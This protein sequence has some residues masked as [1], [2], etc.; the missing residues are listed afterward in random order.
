M[1]LFRI[2]SRT[3]GSLEVDAENW[4]TA[5][6]E[7]LGTFGV[8][9]S[10]DRIACEALPNGQI[11]VRDVRTGSGWVVAPLEG[12]T[13][14]DEALVDDASFPQDPDEPQ[15]GGVSDALRE[16]QGALTVEEAARRAVEAALQLVPAE[17]GAVLVRQADDA[18]K[19][20]F[21]SGPGS[22]HLLGMRVPAGAGVAGFCVRRGTALAL[23]DAYADPRFLKQM[24]Q[25][26]GVRTRSLLC[27]PV[28]R[29]RR[30]LGCI[31]LINGRSSVGF[32]RNA[33][34][35]V[36]LI[37]DALARRIAATAPTRT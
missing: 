19:F 23:R 12:G 24:D 8:V 7:A 20:V 14:D 35:D 28:V 25:I 22:E 9:D 17:G 21:A 6:G 30:A 11:L 13:E 15:A 18:L 33:M 31:E 37:A 1:P 27:M 32:D 4:L 10:M 29:D 3:R 34:A 26:T 2:S 36:E 5:L 16:I